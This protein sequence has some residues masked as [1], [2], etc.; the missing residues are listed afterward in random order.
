M[1][2]VFTRL[3][4]AS[5]VVGTLIL[6]SVPA[7][8]E[9]KRILPRNAV[10]KYDDSGKDL[11]SAWL[12]PDFNDQAWKGGKSPLGFGDDVSE[13]DPT[14]PVGTVVG[15]GPDAANKNMTTYFRTT[16]DV[17][18][19]SSFTDL[20][21]YIHVDDG[22]VVYLNGKELLR[23]GIKDGEAVTFTTA[24]K[25]KP[26]EESL[27]LPVS[28]LK[29]GR[30]VLAA[31]VHQ[32][33]GD[34][35]D[36]WWEMGID[37]NIPGGLTVLDRAA[38]WK[39]DDSGKDGGAAWK[40]AEFDDKAWKV[41]KAPLGFGDDVSETDPALPVGTV[42]GFGADPA[43]KNMTTYFRT[44]FDVPSLAGY[45][46]LKVYVHVD[47]GAV[48][49]LNG[50]ELFR[51]GLKDGEAVA[52][53]T[54]AKFKPKEETF[55]LPVS[56]LKPGRNVL[57]AE[58]H[59]DGGDSSDLWWE[60][61]IVAVGAN[62]GAAP[63]PKAT[64]L[65]VPDPKASLGTVT[66]VVT[67][68]YGDPKTE[69]GFAWYTTAAS[70]KSDVQIVPRT[71]EK[72]N[73]AQAKT[74]PGAWS[75]PANSP[76]QVLHK[77][78][79]TG[80]T[81]NTSYW[82]RV[83]DAGRNLWSEI[84]SFKTAPASGA[85]TFINLAD[86]QAKNEEEALLSAA[87]FAKAAATVKN[88]AFL[89]INGDLVDVGMQEL[90]WDWLL[91]HSAPT[92]RQLPF[93]P[94]AGNHDE[95][96]S[97]FIDHFMLKTPAGV[98][99]VSGAYYSFD[100]SNAHCVVLN[101][102]EDSKEWADLTPAQVDWLTADVQAAR[103]AGAQWVFVFLHKG[104]YTT[105]N[106]ATD[107][108]M[109]DPNGVRTKF[110]PLLSTLGVDLVFQGHDH[111]YAR[112]WP[113]QNG[114]AI[115]GKDAAKIEGGA[116]PVYIIPATAGPKTYY[117]NKKIDPAFYDLFAVADENHAA[118]YG[119]EPSDKSRPLRSAVQNFLSVT[120][121]GK[122]VSVVTYE[123]DEQVKQGEPFVVDQFSITKK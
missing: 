96:K 50:T 110:A 92:L 64:S 91:G 108:D 8:A 33:G 107:M 69:M 100:W 118:K 25:F 40:T 2:N 115:K 67:T 104:P 23:R 78:A 7:F 97:S 89:S 95:D 28:V 54:A 77:T 53:A 43:N 1:K 59:Q 34:S 12:S 99:T 36:L 121:D 10:W 70:D 105:S 76:T 21:V 42:V 93:V 106:H 111:I 113:I 6:G 101:T 45:E 9:A 80:L 14:L 3:L 27:T 117:K 112:T 31:E 41:G 94:A 83:G 122:Q 5:V 60:M 16:F 98:S 90:Q 18:D 71:S 58:V 102:N 46:H 48:V 29:A 73:F 15:F 116:G 24:G 88:A 103:K 39:Y 119:P 79:A 85:F 49:Y 65:L 44:A 74:F 68:V 30:N 63:A 4:F 32:D 55:T 72:P 66:K 87:T 57:A 120:V 75:L 19:L 82:Y 123:I 61:G 62:Q 20:T 81:P 84:G 26:K 56:A 51:R 38:P 17:A 11:G 37:G 22:A 35:S 114:K 47:D 13:T 86:S 109:M 52:F